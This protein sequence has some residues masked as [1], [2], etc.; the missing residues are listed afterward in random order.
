MGLTDVHVK[1]PSESRLVLCL[2]LIAGPPSSTLSPYAALFRSCMWRTRSHDLTLPLLRAVMT[3]IH[4][5]RPGP[6]WSAAHTSAR[7]RSSKCGW[8]PRGVQQHD[9]IPPLVAATLRT[10]SNQELNRGSGF[11]ER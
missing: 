4:S 7:Q 11:D 8:R 1:A 6:S 2:V 5:T 3:S 10:A 9:T